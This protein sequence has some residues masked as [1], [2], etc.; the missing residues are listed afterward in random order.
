MKLNSS[1]H[2]INLY[3]FLTS[4]PSSYPSLN[5]ETPNV[6]S[7]N[8]YQDSNIN[9]STFKYHALNEFTEYPYWDYDSVNTPS[10]TEPEINMSE[11]VTLDDD[12]DDTRRSSSYEIDK[13]AKKDK[14][15]S[16]LKT[17]NAKRFKEKID[18]NFLNL[19]KTYTGDSNDPMEMF[20]VVAAASHESLVG[21]SNTKPKKSPSQSTG[22]KN[23]KMFKIKH[24]KLLP[25]NEKHSEST[26]SVFNLAPAAE[27][28]DYQPASSYDG[29]NS[30]ILGPFA[31]TYLFDEVDQFNNITIANDKS[32]DQPK[33]RDPE[34]LYLDSHNPQCIDQESYPIHTPRKY[35]CEICKKRF[36]RPSTL[37]THINSHTG[38]RPY[39]CQAQGCDWRFTVLSNL[40]R[41]S[42]ICVHVKEERDLMA[43]GTH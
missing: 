42:K 26:F 33:S 14:M 43:A 2:Q 9:E 32:M 25:A 18:P 6:K 24:V 17:K 31:H 20:S 19:I 7:D 29:K 5:L 1:Q 4:Y 27:S 39:K 16:G 22:K 38:V 41:H 11:Y 40:K 3:P 36:T 13:V 10:G 28:H 12:E 23:K 15:Y 35:L 30:T 34:A 21:L 8:F 37:K